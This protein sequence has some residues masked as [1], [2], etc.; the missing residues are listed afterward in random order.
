MSEDKKVIEKKWDGVE[1]RKNKSVEKKKA[2]ASSLNL[3]FTL[4]KS[5]SACLTMSV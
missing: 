1:R 5:L 2:N 3:S 4:A